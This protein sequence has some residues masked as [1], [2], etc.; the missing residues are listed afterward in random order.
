VSFNSTF[1]SISTISWR[2]VFIGR[3]SPEYP[4]R[5]TDP[6]QATDKLDHLRL[7]DECTL[8]VIY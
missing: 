3:G 4:E 1:S 2:P 8:F 6:D 5:T 7:R